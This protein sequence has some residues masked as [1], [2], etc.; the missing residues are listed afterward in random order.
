MKRILSFV[1]IL[2][3]LLLFTSCWSP[4]YVD[5]HPVQDDTYSL[6]ENITPL[7]WKALHAS[8]IYVGGLYVSGALDATGSFTTDNLTVRNNLAVGNR[9]FLS[10]DP[11]NLYEPVT[12]NYLQS[13]LISAGS[14]I[15]NTDT[16]LTTDGVTPLIDAGVLENDL[17]T[18]RWLGYSSNTFL[19]VDVAGSDNLAHTGGN[20]GEGNTAFGY[21]ALED[22]TTSY[23]NTAVGDR[24]LA[25]I[26]TGL[27]NTAVG[28][29]ALAS[30]ILGSFN[31]AVGMQ[32]LPVN[33]GSYNTAIGLFT[34]HNN[35]VGSSNVFI[36][37][38]A[39]KNELGSEQLYI[40]VTDTTTPLIRGSFASDNLTINGDLYVRDRSYVTYDPVADNEVVPKRYLDAAI[41][42][43]G[44]IGGA[45]TAGTIPKF[46]AATTL[47]DSIITDSGT[48]VTITGGLV[49]TE[50]ITMSAG[51][52]VDGVDVSAHAD[53]HEYGGADETNIKDQQMINSNALMSPGGGSPTSFTTT[54]TG[55]RGSAYSTV[56]TI[57]ANT[58][59]PSVIN[60]VT[61]FVVWASD[62]WLDYSLQGNRYRFS[63]RMASASTTNKSEMWVGYFSNTT[64]FPTVTSNH[65][66]LRLIETA[67]AGDGNAILYASNGNGVNGTQ[68]QIETG[69]KQYDIW[70]YSIK[71][72]AGD[73]KFYEGMNG[74]AIALKA[75]HTTNRP[76]WTGGYFGIWVKTTDTNQ[77]W[78]QCFYPQVMPGGE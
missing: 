36:G 32:S 53:R 76:Q 1:L 65:I 16:I 51:K 78:V 50:N 14:H 12:L 40:D 24:A 56:A 6:G 52:L 73:I 13:A 49:V 20:E 62:Y 44:G 33:T 43:A 22:I 18:D 7:R 58:G 30:T 57:F 48:A 41:A 75:T 72:M 35:I 10:R 67:G 3:S 19:G 4:I 17:S 5:T 69:G 77:K 60:D 28:Q 2:A 37:S 70:D 31:T 27:Y 23:F 46:S 15:Q 59:N 55:G 42:G 45:G 61:G 39:G 74:A 54:L 47:T 63:G 34:G 64:T 66:A 26:T 8:N 68:T 29:L 11:V 38:S 9:L 71:Y 25:N 21:R